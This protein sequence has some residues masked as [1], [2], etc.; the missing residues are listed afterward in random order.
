MT[1][2]GSGVPSMPLTPGLSKKGFMEALLAPTNMAHG[3]HFSEERAGEMFMEQHSQVVVTVR[4]EGGV[5]AL[6]V[7]LRA[8]HMYVCVCACEYVCLEHVL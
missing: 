7:I 3:Q 2:D 8:H 1:S 6:W 5:S 4:E